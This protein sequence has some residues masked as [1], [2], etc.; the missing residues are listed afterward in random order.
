MLFNSFSVFIMIDD[1]PKETLESIL[2][3]GLAK[4][5][6]GQNIRINVLELR[7]IMKMKLV[8]EDAFRTNVRCLN[9]RTKSPL[10]CIL[11]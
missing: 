2:Y 8:N 4:Y 9:Q 3:N 6:S 11:L 7:K 5:I 10:E 1:N